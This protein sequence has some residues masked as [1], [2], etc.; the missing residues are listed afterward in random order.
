MKFKVPPIDICQ[1]APFSSDP[2]HREPFAKLLNTTIENVD[3]NLVISVDSPWGHGKTTFAKQWIQSLENNGKKV[4]LFN[5]FENDLHEDPFISF[6]GEI[7]AFITEHFSKELKFEEKP[8]LKNAGKLASV[9]T[10]STLKIGLNAFSAGIIDNK[11]FEDFQNKIADTAGD[12]CGEMI[13][14]YTNK[15]EFSNKFRVDLKD[16]ANLVRK[17]QGFPLTIIIDELDRCRPD[18]A[19]QLL[20]RI[21]HYFNVDNVT[22]VLFICEKQFLNHVTSTYGLNKNIESYLHKFA[23]LFLT[24]PNGKPL[25]NAQAYFHYMDNTAKKMSLDSENII[26]TS[27]QLASLNQCSMRQCNQIL[28]TIVLSS[29]LIPLD[30][31]WQIVALLIFFKV[32]N[33]ELLEKMALNIFN[34]NDLNGIYLNSAKLKGTMEHYE[35]MMMGPGEYESK[36]KKHSYY[37][38]IGYSAFRQNNAQ[39]AKI[40]LG[41]RY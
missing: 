6:T 21:K 8:F 23:D 28:S 29:N 35:F 20:E 4:I 19:L 27:S 5:A 1:A 33:I 25:N 31:H 37:V 15:K 30:T 17:K 7:Y 11:I 12:M 24:L 9:L 41:T 32:T 14:N 36:Q 18:F 10:T 3:D 34:K 22:F 2:F 39:L 38:N 26:Y 16:L 40:L 13:E